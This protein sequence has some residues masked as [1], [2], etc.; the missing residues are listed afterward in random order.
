MWQLHDFDPPA[1]PH[2]VTDLFV[3]GSLCEHLAA[4]VSKVK[5]ES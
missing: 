5:N 2:F 3:S 1:Q 4:V